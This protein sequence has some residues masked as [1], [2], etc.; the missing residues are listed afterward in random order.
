M[1]LRSPLPMSGADTFPDPALAASAFARP[2][3]A[4]QY[5]AA[6]PHPPVALLDLLC[7]YA[8]VDRPQLVVDL[9]CGTGLSTIAWAS[10]AARVVGI[11]P[12]AGMLAVARRRPSVA[13][14]EFR[15]G[16]GHT[17]GLPAGGADVVTAVQAFH[18]M[19]PEA[20]LAEV[21]RLLRPGGVFAAADYDGPPSADWELEEAAVRVARTAERLRRDLGSPYVWPHKWP[22]AGHL[23]VLRQSGHFRFVKEVLLHSA[24]VWSAERYVGATLNGMVEDLEDLQARGVTEEQLGL[25]ELRQLA[26][27]VLGADGRVVVSWRVRLGVHA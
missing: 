21:T 23:Q 27:R 19:P 11:E 24:E 4:A 5:D 15:E 9:G 7:R 1:D 10:R 6:R 25:T 26:G 14:V 17:T 13:T 2:S 12:A 18:W 3:F 22:K 8:R 16:H 20:T